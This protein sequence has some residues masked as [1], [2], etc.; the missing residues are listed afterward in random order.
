MRALEKPLLLLVGD[1]DDACLEPAFFMKR[2]VRKSGLS[3]F[4]RSGHAIN[5]EETD[6]FNHVVLDFLTAVESGAWSEREY[7]SSVGF[8][9][10]EPGAPKAVADRGRQTARSAS[11]VST[12]ILVQDP[13]HPSYRSTQPGCEPGRVGVA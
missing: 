1:E 2:H 13:S 3:V 9:V 7:G 12:V 10:D 4:P 11:G 8:L 6:L 5:L